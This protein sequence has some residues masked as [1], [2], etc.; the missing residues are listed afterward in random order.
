LPT[1]V[2]SN[3]E[4]AEFSILLGSGDTTGTVTITATYDADA[5]GTAVAA[6]TTV[7]S[8]VIGAAPATNQKLTVGTFKGY[9]AIYALNYTGQKLSAKVAGKWLTQNNLSRFERV[10]RLTGAGYTIKVDLYI[11]GAFVRSETVVT[12]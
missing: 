7:R 4:T 8:V 12:K 1:K 3:G 2:G 11:D 5:T 6:I 9:V 10:V